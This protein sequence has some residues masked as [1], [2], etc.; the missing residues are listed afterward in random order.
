MKPDPALLIRGSGEVGSA[1][2]LAL[3][4][5]GYRPVVQDDPAPATLRRGMA[6]SDA[7]FDG[8]ALLDG[9]PACRVDGLDDLRE[10]VQA[11]QAIPVT[12]LPVADLLAAQDWDV[13]VDARLR[14]RSVPEDQ[15]GLAGL[16]IGLGPNFVAGG[17]VDI[18]IE[19]SW[20]ALGTIIRKGPTL[21]LRGE[22]RPIG[23]VGRDRNVYAMQGGVVQTTHH[24]GDLVS[25]GDVL[26]EI[27]GAPFIAPLP[28]LLRGLVRSGVRV[29]KGAKLAEIDPRGSTGHCFGVGER[30]ARL[31]A[32][33]LKLIGGDRQYP[34][35]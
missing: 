31:A 8:R 28:G 35:D 18:A 26:G 24:I 30:P 22:P 13:L 17:T 10:T 1:I 11:G 34:A 2:A 21:P 3:F 9:V 7:L 6:F 32:E 14:K 19:T 29:D 27:E 23:G 4:R 12:A 25:E 5:G 20:E 16:T 33:V 15:R